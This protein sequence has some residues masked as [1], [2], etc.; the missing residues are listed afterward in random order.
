MRPQPPERMVKLPAADQNQVRLEILRYVVYYVF[1]LA[2]AHTDRESSTGISLHTV[3]RF[4]RRLEEK[5][6]ER[7]IA[8]LGTRNGVNE[9]DFA[10]PLAGKFRGPSDDPDIRRM[11]IHRAQQPFASI[12]VCRIKVRCVHARVH[13]AFSIVQDLG[14]H[15]SQKKPPERTI[16][17]RR[18]HDQSDVVCFGV[19]NDLA[20]RVS[21]GQSPV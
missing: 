12:G 9:L 6:T 2:A 16:T 10:V 1:R 11:N 7:F 4:V 3:H 19:G 17:M 8:A 14:R 18:H 13:G 21:F 15:G 5:L 20:R